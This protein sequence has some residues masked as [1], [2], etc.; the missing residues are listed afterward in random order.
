[1]TRDEEVAAIEAHIRARGA[2]RVP[3]SREFA[4]AESAGGYAPLEFDGAKKKY[5]RAPVTR[6][7]RWVDDVTRPAGE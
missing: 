2:R 7:R 6:L 1:M 4:A 5:T 3:S